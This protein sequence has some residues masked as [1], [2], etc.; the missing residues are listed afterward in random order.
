MP[1]NGNEFVKLRKSAHRVDVQFDTGVGTA[2]RGT[3]GSWEKQGS[4][5]PELPAGGRSI[6]GALKPSGDGVLG[7]AER[8]S[9]AGVLGCIGRYSAH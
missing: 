6:F 1:D 3:E 9:G 8:P 7:R 4:G 5:R 2:Q